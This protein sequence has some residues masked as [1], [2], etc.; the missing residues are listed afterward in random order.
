MNKIL[1][2]YVLLDILFLGTGILLLTTVIV[3]KDD[4]TPPTRANVAWKMLLSLC[5]L[6]AAFVNGIFIVLAFLVSLPGVVLPTNRMWLRLHG[7]LIVFCIFFT[8][9]MGL[10]VW[11]RTLKTRSNLNVL[12]TQQSPQVQGL[13]QDTFNC[14]GYIN[15]TTPPFQT[16]SVC[17]NPLAAAQMPGCIVPFSNFAN[18]YLS[19]LFTASF[20][21]V[22][23]DVLLILCVAMVL[24]QR[25]EQK[26]YRH[27]DEKNGLGSI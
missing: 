22:A 27:I 1:L 19:V 7:W 21:I 10:E 2:S 3:Q 6:R 9:A 20:G 14:C 12:W 17:P 18:K 23:L 8:L 24:K 13:L 16:N 5:P 26:R 4:K 25:R 11:I 15:S